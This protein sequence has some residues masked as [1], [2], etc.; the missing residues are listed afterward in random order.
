MPTN[1]SVIFSIYTKN[2]KLKHETLKYLFYVESKKRRNASPTD[3]PILLP[4]PNEQLLKLY[5]EV[6]R[7]LIPDDATISFTA[8]LQ[9]KI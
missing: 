6:F 7:P 4:I 3:P 5:C 8:I 1:V 9:Y 2:Q